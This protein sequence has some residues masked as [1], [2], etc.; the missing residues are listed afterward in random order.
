MKA[1]KIKFQ[2]FSREINHCHKINVIQ[3]ICQYFNDN[4]PWLPLPLSLLGGGGA[5]ITTST[6]QKHLYYKNRV[7]DPYYLGLTLKI[8]QLHNFW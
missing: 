1:K 2:H 3:A 7:F 6:V 5:E 8:R 4:Y